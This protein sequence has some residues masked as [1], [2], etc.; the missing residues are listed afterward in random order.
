MV[1]SAP[2][3]S[4]LPEVDLLDPDLSE[5]ARRVA[6]AAL[7]QFSSVGFHGTTTRG[8]SLGAGVSA[9]APYTH[10]ESKAHILGHWMLRGHRDA[11]RVAREA[12]ARG[13]T[14][15]ECIEHFVHDLTLWHAHHSVLSRVVT[16]QLRALTPEH[17]AVIAELR[18][19]IEA[20]LRT[21][22]EQGLAIDHFHVEDVGLTMNAIFA[23]ILDVPRWLPASTTEP[24]RVALT[25][26]R[27][28][29]GMLQDS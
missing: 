13:A 6:V 26:A 29:L 1:T 3:P 17:F 4:E 8:I 16:S 20:C 14:P 11:L 2:S 19:E 22:I 23:L 18:R 5:P 25:Y 7:R 10:F 28:A 9:G 24:E 12:V 15:T 27:L 21:P